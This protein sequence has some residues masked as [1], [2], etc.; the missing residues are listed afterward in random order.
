MPL[1]G[2]RA[3]LVA[4]VLTALCCVILA[5]PL[6]HHLDLESTEFVISEPDLRVPML[7]S[8]KWAAGRMTGNTR[9]E[10]PNLAAYRN[11]FAYQ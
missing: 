4:T 10:F 9:K 3:V 1:T 7:S 5:H 2:A 11:N 8:V 6:L